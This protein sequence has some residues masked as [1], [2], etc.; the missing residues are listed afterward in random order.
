[1]TGIKGEDRCE[2]PY[3]LARERPCTNLSD[4]KEEGRARRTSFRDPAAGQIQ[5]PSPNLPLPAAC[6]AAP[7]THPAPA[8][9]RRAAPQARQSLSSR[10]H[11]TAGPRDP[12]RRDLFR[13][14]VP[15]TSRSLLASASA[16][17]LIPLLSSPSAVPALVPG[18]CRSPA[19]PALVCLLHGHQIKFLYSNAF[20]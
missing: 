8:L 9:R 14:L 19:L 12:R 15:G 13:S 10:V 7:A 5:Q 18:R 17:F 2:G 6:T 1:M 4:G 20:F 3:K 11:V 16:R